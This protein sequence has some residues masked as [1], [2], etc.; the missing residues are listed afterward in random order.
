GGGASAREL[1]DGKPIIWRD[2]LVGEYGAELERSRRRLVLAPERGGA[3]RLAHQIAE[4]PSDHVPWLS[5]PNVPSST[6]DQYC[7]WLARDPE[8]DTFIELGMWLEERARAAG[9]RHLVVLRHDGGPHEHLSALGRLLRV[10][11]EDAEQRG[12]R[13]AVLVAGKAACARLR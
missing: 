13:L 7:A 8:V 9:G 10:L 11:L 6:Q 1:T 2:A 12:L 5:P 3:S 4:R